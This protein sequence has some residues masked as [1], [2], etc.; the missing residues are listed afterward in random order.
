MLTARSFLII[1]P[2]LFL[3]GLVDSIGGGGGLISL[4][5]YVFAGLPMHACIATN[6]LSSAC[7]TTLTTVRFIRNGLVRL[8]IALPSAAAGIIGSSIGAD[9]SLQIPEAVLKRMLLVVLPATAALVLNKRLF[10]DRE[11]PAGE[12]DMRTVL[13]AVASALIIGVYDG[14]YG[15]GTGTFLIIAFNVFA[16]MS[17]AKAN[18]H[19]KVINLSTN[20]AALAVY[21]M[22]GQV[23]VAAG[24]AGAAC[25]MLGNY[26]GSG[27]AMKK[28]AGITKP[29]ILLVLSLLLVRIITE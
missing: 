17:V 24:L 10:H 29:V 22:N 18:A 20:I 25:N 11:D 6:K 7:G 8:K 28:G 12:P 19:C 2:L 4:P 21:L 23:V 26:V 27:A 1:C 5:A 15:P 3:A 13:I 16:K 14:M 9:L